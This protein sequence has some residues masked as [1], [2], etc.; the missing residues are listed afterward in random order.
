MIKLERFTA[1]TVQEVAEFMQLSQ[2]TIRRYIKYGTMKAQKVGGKWYITDENL[3]FVLH[4]DIDSLPS[5]S[6]VS[7]NDDNEVK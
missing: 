3:E 1:Y 6:V 4:G 7:S 2:A 5:P